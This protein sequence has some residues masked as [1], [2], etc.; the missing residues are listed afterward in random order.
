MN[1]YVFET[2][3]L[4]NAHSFTDHH[5][6]FG[7]LYYARLLCNVYYGRKKLRTEEG[8]NRN[9]K[10]YYV[11]HSIIRDIPE[12][13]PLAFYHF[14]SSSHRATVLSYVEARFKRQL[15]WLGSEANYRW[16]LKLGQGLLQE[17]EFRQG[18]QH[19]LA[20][21][22]AWCE[23]YLDK[24]FFEVKGPITNIFEQVGAGASSITRVWDPGKAP[25]VVVY[26]PLFNY[27]GPPHE[28]KNRWSISTGGTAK[29]NLEIQNA[30]RELYRRFLQTH[31][32]QAHWGR[33][34]KPEWLNLS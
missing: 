21:V 12:R 2:D 7:L 18:R 4:L 33:R 1:I 31:H 23:R 11:H 15:T 34:G 26:S 6:R 5:I 16:L 3:P 8:I 32:A 20:P 28:I 27:D 29:L 13:V 9:G 14:P 25:D 10:K 30:Y 19:G 24:L 17:Y 22:Y